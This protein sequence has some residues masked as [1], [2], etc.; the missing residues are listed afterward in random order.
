VRCV[1]QL[2]QLRQSVVREAKAK[3]EAQ[4][5]IERGLVEEVTEA[6]HA[7]PVAVWDDEGGVVNVN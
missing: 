5:L 3:H 4:P 2:D 6:L 7:F 1:E